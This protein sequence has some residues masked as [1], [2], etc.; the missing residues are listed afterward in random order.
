MEKMKEL[1]QKVSQD[2]S[3]Q[4]KYVKLTQE[5]VENQ[6]ALIEKLVDFAKEAGFDVS[7]EEIV[8][9][10]ESMGGNSEGELS[11]TELDSVAGGKINPGLISVISNNFGCKPVIASIVCGGPKFF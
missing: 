7:E 8:E 9:F 10:F 4:E 1:Y 5:N 3:L 6:D 11:E 2:L